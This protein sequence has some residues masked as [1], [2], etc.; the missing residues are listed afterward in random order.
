MN[1]WF[2]ANA[3]DLKARYKKYYGKSP[4]MTRKADIAKELEKGL[5]NLV[6]LKAFWQTTPKL[7]Q[8]L[9]QE[10]IY[11]YQGVINHSRFVAKYGSFP[12]KV[13]GKYSYGV[14]QEVNAYLVFFYPKERN[15][16]NSVHLTLIE[17]LK[18][19]VNPPNAESIATTTVD[20]PL[21][22]EFSLHSRES[23]V[24]TS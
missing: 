3:D 22:A 18:S 16:R 20:S 15:G 6:T 9:I 23:N 24:L 7:E 14:K 17:Q 12:E 19:F 13:K 11:N 1:L 10:V 8:K 21:E 4:S 2:L 5:M